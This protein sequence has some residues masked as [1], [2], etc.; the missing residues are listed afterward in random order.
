MNVVKD[1]I[2]KVK[3]IKNININIIIDYCLAR[4]N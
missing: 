4:I 2:I 3:T 1:I